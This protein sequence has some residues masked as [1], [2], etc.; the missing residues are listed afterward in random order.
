MQTETQSSIA[1]AEE[2]PSSIASAK[3]EHSTVTT[4][5]TVLHNLSDG[6]GID[7]PTLAPEP[8]VAGNQQVTVQSHK[9][10]RKGRVACLPKLQRDM[11]NRML[12]NG[13]P[14][15]NIVAALDEAGFTV[16]ERNISSWATGG[17]LEWRLQQDLVLQNRLDQDDLLD[18]LR[19]DDASELT[20]VGLQAAATR[21]SQTLVQKTAQDIEANIGSYSQLVDLLCRVNRQIAILEKRREDSRRALGREY[22]PARI[23][24]Y[25]QMSAIENERYYSNPPPSSELAKPAEPPSL[26]PVPTSSLLADAD[27]EAEDR[28]KL[29]RQKIFLANLQ[30]FSGK[31]APGSP[32]PK[33]LPPPAGR[34]GSSL[35]TEG[36]GSLR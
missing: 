3:E 28:E 35:G 19:H 16:T 8:S 10:R 24:E 5:P 11:V 7:Q 25:E 22:D 33:S 21:V 1:L 13:V 17:F 15:K 34:A 6:A 12:D 29:A 36:Y 9:A 14:Y 30:A 27:E 4:Q 31:K 2:D 20:E 26:P 32:V 23:K 18:H